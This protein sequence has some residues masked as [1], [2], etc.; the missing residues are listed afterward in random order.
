MKSLLSKTSKMPCA[1]WSIPA[2]KTCPGS[3]KSLAELGTENHICAVCY[4]RKNLYTW[5]G[6]QNAQAERL[7]FLTDSLKK[8]GG[9]EWI[10][11]MVAAIKKTRNPYFRVH[12]SG[13]L[14]SK[15]YIQAWIKVCKQLPKVKFWFP[16]KEWVRREQLPHLRRLAKL[17][18]VVVRP[19]GMMIDGDAPVIKGL[20]KGNTQTT[21]ISK[22]NCPAYLGSDGCE[23]CRKCWD[24]RYTIVGLKH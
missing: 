20:Q 11:A 15:E 16:T 1:S 18:N 14:F 19:S 10:E 12:D 8:D 17:K 9:K 21:D 22:V 13:D 5:P 2:G 24:G 7:K 3:K 4:A 6:V 23:D